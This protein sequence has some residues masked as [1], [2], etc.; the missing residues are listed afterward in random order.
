MVYIFTFYCNW[1]WFSFQVVL[2]ISGN[3]SFLN[4][5]TITPSLACFD[6]A[7]LAWLF[8]GSVKNKVA[9]FQQE[10]REGRSPALTKGW[11]LN[12]YI[13]IVTSLL[14]SSCFKCYSAWYLI[15]RTSPYGCPTGTVGN[16]KVSQ[17]SG[18]CPI[19]GT[20]DL[21]STRSNRSVSSWYLGFTQK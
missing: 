1:F 20:W 19:V 9:S 3:L 16:I 12:Y 4:W 6:D 5:L 7:S 11:L 8:S 17:R 10:D 15:G 18:L 14:S 2:I 21:W 13:W